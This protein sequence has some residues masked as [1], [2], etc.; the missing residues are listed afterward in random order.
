MKDKEYY[1][2]GQVY[3]IIQDG[4]RSYFYKSGK[5]KASGAFVNGQMEGEWK[6]YRENGD[7]CQ[8][9]Y[10]KNSVRTGLWIKFDREGNVINK[11][12]AF[13]GFN[14]NDLEFNF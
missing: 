2:N 6:F 12:F 1:S 7:L 9:G 8:I 14:H 5:L 4:I 10:F 11:K 3:S 13:N